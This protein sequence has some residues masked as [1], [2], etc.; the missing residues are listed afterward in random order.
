MCIHILRICSICP[1]SIRTFSSTVHIKAC[2]QFFHKLV[3]SVLLSP[4]WIAILSTAS[5]VSSISLKCITYGIK[6]WT[7][8][9]RVNNTS[10]EDIGVNRP[11]I[12]S[13]TLLPPA[14]Y[15]VSKL[16]LFSLKMFIDIKYI[17]LVCRLL[18]TWR[19]FGRW[20]HRV[21]GRKRAAMPPRQE[22]VPIMTRGRILLIVPWHHQ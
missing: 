22:N 16:I 20:R 3:A 4:S 9:Q 21:S 10:Y 2:W 17:Y 11:R 12:L 13:R 7:T 15:Q 18:F 19:V 14:E 1:Y 8:S 5:R 6:C